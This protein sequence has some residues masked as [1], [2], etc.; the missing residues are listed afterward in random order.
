[1]STIIQR[2]LKCD[3][4]GRCL[5]TMPTIQRLGL[6]PENHT[7]GWQRTLAKNHGWRRVPPGV[8]YCGE[9]IAT[10]EHLANLRKG[11]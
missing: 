2:F 11:A 8:D 5:G 7:F 6:T 3:C 10:C 1:M 4:C 9:C